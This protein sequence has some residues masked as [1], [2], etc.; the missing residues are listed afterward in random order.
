MKKILAW[1]GVLI[2]LALVASG[3]ACFLTGKGAGAT[4]GFVVGGLIV[5]TY[6]AIFGGDSD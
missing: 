3:I 1:G 5:L 2:A 4:V 6:T